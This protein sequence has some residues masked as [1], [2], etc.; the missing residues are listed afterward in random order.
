MSDKKQGGKV[1]VKGGLEKAVAISEARNLNTSTHSF[2]HT[3]GEYKNPSP[4]APDAK[5]W[6]VF[7]PSPA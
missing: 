1:L 5:A 3:A 4:E 7:A 2:K 6:G